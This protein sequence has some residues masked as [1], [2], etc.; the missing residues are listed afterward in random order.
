[1]TSR[2]ILLVVAAL[3][4]ASAC[5][6]AHVPM[7]TDEVEA[8]PPPPA[9]TTVS[10]MIGPEGGR[11]E[12]GTLVLEV[13]PGAVASRQEISITVTADRVPGA[14]TA[15]SPVYRFGPDGA[16]FATP[17]RISIPYSGHS[18]LATI[19]WTSE[20][21][22]GAYVPLETT[23]EGARAFASVS[24]FSEGFVGTSCQGDDCCGRANGEL[25]VL[26]MIDNSNS[27][28]EEQE[29]LARELPRM[30]R[31][32]AS[33][34]LEGDGVQDF[35]AVRSLHYGVVSSDMGTGGY[36]V[37]T[38]NEPNFGDDGILRTLGNT[39]MPGCMATYAPV[40]QYGEGLGISAE[41]FATNATC[42]AQMGTG[43]CGFEQQLDAVAKALTPSTSGMTFSMGTDGHG[44]VENAGLLREDSAIAV[45]ML[46]DEEDCSAADPGLYD[47]MTSTYVG[48]LNLRCF[49]YPSAVQPIGR[50]TDALLA[51]RPDNPS[52]IVFAAI[53]GIPTHLSTPDGTNFDEILADPEMTE[54]IDTS[55]PTP[56]LMP[57]CNVPGRGIAFP[58]RRIV[59]A[60]QR[61]EAGGGNGMVHSICQ[62]DYAPA[63]SAI[64]ERVGRSLSGACAPE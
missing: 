32:L 41:E 1:M 11:V 60:A 59:G 22:G 18:R 55:S 53:T 43:G 29:S 62:E 37:P 27:M 8:D 38:C 50:Y 23:V 45:V 49:M 44:D 6:Q 48:D 4:A 9:G 57:S 21:G 39:S 3:V 30:A 40:H 17:L 15:Y 42:V 64:L 56:R 16:T 52:R 13:P 2:R 33:G 51:L 5:T 35:P 19:F 28:T 7:P 61:I 31:I 34:D 63:V 47:P 46:T 24:H 58:P 26:F 25:D 10:E 54:A 12:I 14:F 36:R 20:D